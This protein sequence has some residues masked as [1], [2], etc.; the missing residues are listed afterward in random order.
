MFILLSF[1]T[2]MP[3]KHNIFQMERGCLQPGCRLRGPE[4]YSLFRFVQRLGVFLVFGGSAVLLNFF[5]FIW[6]CSLEKTMP[7]GYAKS[8]E[9]NPLNYDN[10]NTTKLDIFSYSLVSVC[11]KAW[12]NSWRHFKV[13]IC[14]MQTRSPL[15]LPNNVIGY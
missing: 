3:G 7:N 2:I 1:R 10:L 4:V 5:Q 8:G 11:R 6:L 9:M 13:Q 12:L 14:L 15:N